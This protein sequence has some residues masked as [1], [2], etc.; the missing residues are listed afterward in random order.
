MRCH[1]RSYGIKN[2]IS[3]I[4]CVFC[5]ANLFA[6][7]KEEVAHMLLTLAEAV[8]SE[9][10]PKSISAWRNNIRYHR[11]VQEGGAVIESISDLTSGICKTT[12]NADHKS[13]HAAE[14]F[15]EATLDAY[16]VILTN[17]GFRRE[18]KGSTSTWLKWVNGGIIVFHIISSVDKNTFR[19]MQEF[20][21]VFTVY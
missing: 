11:E 18:Q 14:V 8:T 4:L 7:E 17:N 5:F 12:L 20:I 9:L 15:I 19:S 10:V 2:L 13:V 1:I 21:S 6:D 3:L 16:E